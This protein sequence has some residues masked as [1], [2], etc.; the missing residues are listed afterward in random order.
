M[1]GRISITEVHI[2]TLSSI[3][4]PL[5]ARTYSGDTMDESHADLDATAPSCPPSTSP[6]TFR[7][8]PGTREGL[9]RHLRSDMVAKERI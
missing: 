7:V 4:P 5:T 3:T 8:P 9:P 6:L 2:S 1:D